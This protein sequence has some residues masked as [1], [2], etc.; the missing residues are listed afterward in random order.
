M[1]CS[2]AHG[3][4]TLRLDCAARMRLGVDR[5]RTRPD[6]GPCRSPGNRHDACRLGLSMA[7]EYVDAFNMDLHELNQV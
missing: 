7:R 2:M 5:P 6:T 3:A 4:K 1:L